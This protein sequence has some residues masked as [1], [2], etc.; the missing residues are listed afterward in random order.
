M[1]KKAD[2][3]PPTITPVHRPRKVS[4]SKPPVTTSARVRTTASKAL[5]GERLTP[6][7][8]RSLA[9]SEERHIEPRRRPKNEPVSPRTSAR[10][11]REGGIGLATPAKLTRKQRQ[12]LG[13][14]V[15]AHIEPRS[16]AKPTGKRTPAK[17][18]STR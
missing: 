4:I 15:M 18:P 5:R 14:S 16:S 9:G 1:P 7:E 6:K 17:P 13:A 2:R 8:V 3:T 12:S 11:E 10:V